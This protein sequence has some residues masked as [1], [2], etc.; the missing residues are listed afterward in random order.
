MG[1]A[2]RFKKILGK[3]TFKKIDITY[4]L[5]SIKRISND[6]KELAICL[7]NTGSSFLGVKNATL[8]LFPHKTLVLPA[9]Y[10]NIN[11]TD[12]QLLELSEAILK[13]GFNQVI[14][15]TLPI[16]MNKLLDLIAEKII[17]K[18]IF[19]GALSE[20]SNETNEKQFFNM[21]QLAQTNKIK[22]IGFVKS[23]LEMWSSSLFSIS[24]NQLQLKPM[25]PVSATMNFKKSN[26]INIGIFGN[27]SFNKNLYNQIAGALAVEN[28]VIH[29]SLQTK[30]TEF[31]FD[32]RI[33]VHPFMD[34]LTFV[35]LISQMDINLHLSFSEGMGGQV[36]TESLAA[37]VPCLTSYNNEY[38]KHDLEL[39]QLLT[40]EQYE[41]PWQISKSIEQVISLDLSLLEKRLKD[42]SLIIEKEHE[43][44]LESF[45]S[46][47]SRYK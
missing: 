46:N 5:D 1:V 3:E 7:E 26:K 33:I 38:L 22:K 8:N 32:D 12:G 42:Y 15:S 14:I 36:F 19:H 17:V 40:V 21:I 16:S 28:T 43:N 24:T 41:N 18:V 10:S 13:S 29:T 6:S 20:L 45:L 4:L 44:L 37:G 25:A 27:S 23:G 34:H 2:Y 11:L 35:Q 39:Q 9:Y 30:F 31:G 47:Q